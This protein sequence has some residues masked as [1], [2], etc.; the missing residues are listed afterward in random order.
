MQASPLSRGSDAYWR[1]PRPWLPSSRRLGFAAVELVCGVICG[2][3]RPVFTDEGRGNRP[4]EVF[5]LRP[6]DGRVS[7][8]ARLP[9]L[10]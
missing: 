3:A 4:A 8:A 5:A 9:V 2:G 6:L 1:W 10:P 7:G